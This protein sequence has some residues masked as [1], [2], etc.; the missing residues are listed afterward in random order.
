MQRGDETCVAVALRAGVWGAMGRWPRVCGRDRF[1]SRPSGKLSRGFPE[2]RK[3]ERPEGR[4]V[5]VSGRG[6]VPAAA[7][8]EGP[9]G[10]AV[11]S[12]VSIFLK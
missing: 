2:R 8:P 1:A 12:R 9:A 7:A 11:A 3:A 4:P 5:G 6:R 10:S